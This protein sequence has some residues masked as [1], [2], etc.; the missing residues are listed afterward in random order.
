MPAVW[1]GKVKQTELSDVITIQLLLE[2]VNILKTFGLVNGRKCNK[3][4]NDFAYCSTCFFILWED[5]SF[6]TD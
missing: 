2:L 5:G 6:G 1:G 3:I 4:V